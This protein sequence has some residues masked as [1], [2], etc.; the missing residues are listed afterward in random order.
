MPIPCF[1]PAFEIGILT[2]FAGMKEVLSQ[3]DFR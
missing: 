1:H 3:K 2:M